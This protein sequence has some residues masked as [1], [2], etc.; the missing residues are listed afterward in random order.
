MTIDLLPG[1]TMDL[2]DHMHQEDHM[3]EWEIDIVQLVHVLM[4]DKILVDQ[5]D[6]Q[7][8]SQDH[9][10]HLVEVFLVHHQV[11]LVDHL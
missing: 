9:L 6:I 2:I 5:I 3:I 8:Y 1:T 10:H 4:Q 11:H 7:V